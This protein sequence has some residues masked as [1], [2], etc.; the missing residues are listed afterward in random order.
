[1]ARQSKPWYRSA[2]DVWYVT[3]AGK[4]VNLRVTGRDNEAAAVLA[5]QQL[6]TP[7]PPSP[8]PAAVTQVGVG[9]VLGAFLADA[10]G[11]VAPATLALYKLFLTPFAVAFGPL[12][13]NQ[14]TPPAVEQHSRKATWNE[15]TRS[16]FLSVVGRVFKFAERARLIDRTPLVGLRKPPI[17]SR[18][19]DTMVTRADHE[20]LAAAS[21][22]H[23]RPFL[24]FLFQTGCRPSE[25]AGLTAAD[26]DWV[27]TVAVVRQH[28]TKAKGKRRVLYLSPEALAVLRKFADERPTGL[29]FR[30]RIG[31]PWTRFTISEGM[32]R[33]SRKAGLPGKIA[34][35]YRHGFATDA[36]ATGVPDAHV[37]ELL[38]HSS[39]A[40][41]HKHY[42]HLATR[43]KLLTD[44][45]GRVRNV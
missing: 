44:A 18:A 39:T 37:A 36:L 35:G 23:F 34:Y 17:T 25:A 31:K 24:T 12:A 3:I 22:P 19:A 2:L 5:W 10:A 30:N 21:P 11:R 32:R 8:K 41:L 26:V 13:V 6:T 27:A 33:A 45:A 9:D 16:A 29:L 4:K 43:V 15:S 20:R 7:V 40:M 42:S 14:L 38:G 1:M 28:K